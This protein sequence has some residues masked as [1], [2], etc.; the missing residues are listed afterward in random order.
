MAVELDVADGLAVVRLARPERRNSLDTE[1]VAAISAAFDEAE[2]SSEV[3]AVIVIGKGTSFC[4]GATL[5]TLIAAADGEFESVEHVYEG[6]L[7]ILRSPLPTIA[8][9]NGAAVG[10]GLN[11]AL[12]CDVRLASTGARFESRFAELHLHPGG[13]H[14]WLL[15]RAI[16]R[17]NATLMTMFNEVVDAAR[18]QELGL[19]AS[20]HEPDS[21]ELAARALGGRLRD[22]DHQFVRSV[23]RTLR[24]AEQTVNHSEFLAVETQR[25]RSSTLSSEFVRR[26]KAIQRRISSAP[27]RPATSGMP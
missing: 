25:Q 9:V 1:M 12:A 8:A 19:V 16:G 6:F 22:Y 26:T 11:V 23:A 20:V 18:A 13:G 3:N 7:R 5:D 4:A 17:Q 15:E 14:T 21:L 27:P 10:A 24:E 2:A